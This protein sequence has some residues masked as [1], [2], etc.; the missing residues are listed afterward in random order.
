MVI[1]LET[2][3]K[4]IVFV[5]PLTKMLNIK[6]TSL[7]TKCRHQLLCFVLYVCLVSSL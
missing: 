5:L 3:L 1:S 2:R 7:P 4:A 6:S